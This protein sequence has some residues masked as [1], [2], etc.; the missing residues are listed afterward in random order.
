MRLQASILLLLVAT[1]FSGQAATKAAAPRAPL[2]KILERDLRPVAPGTVGE[3][4]HPPFATGDCSLCHERA[5]AANPGK[6]IKAGNDL[7]FG[8]HEDYPGILSRKFTHL[9]A[10][11]RCVSCHNPHNS[12]EP[13]LLHAPLK[14][15]CFACHEEIQSLAEKSLVKHG[16]IAAEAKCMACHNPHGADVEH[17]LL[18]M[19]RDLCLNC[20]SRDGVKDAEGHRITNMKRLLD[21]NPQHHGALRFGDCSACHNPHGFEHFRLLN[22]QYP[23]EFYSHYDPALYAL[24]FE[25][26]E[27]SAFTE[28]QT[29]TLTQ[30]R[31]GSRNLHHLH[32]NKDELGRTCRACHEVHASKLPHLIRGSVPYGDSGWMLKINYTS[33]LTGG[34]CSKT[35]H[36]EEAYDNSIVSPP[37]VPMAAQQPLARISRASVGTQIPNVELM[38]LDGVKR[39][40]F[41]GSNVTVLVFF[42]PDQEH[43]RVALQQITPVMREFASKPV[44]WIGLVSDRFAK[45]NVLEEV[46][47]RGVELPVLIDAG[48]AMYG[49]FGVAQEPA[50]GFIDRNHK[51]AAFQAF[52]KVNQ[53]E[54]LRARVHHLLGE[55][56]DH[57]LELVLRPPPM[58]T[59][60]PVAGAHTRL[61]LAERLFVAGRTQL[62]LEGVKVSLTEDPKSV[63]AHVLHGR[64]LVGLGQQVEARAAFQTALQIEPG[65]IEARQA[66]E[67]AAQPGSKP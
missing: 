15:L 51:Y 3:T 35:C 49:R 40:L 18:Q 37:V 50:F 45:S 2:P 39:G 62:A 48:D 61:R 38:T 57:Q 36:G 25:C 28:A 47:R 52:A 6:V 58:A 27:A 41:Q 20:H 33:T 11:E 56:S 4:S 8:C 5:D 9:A 10:S 19:P 60:G 67:A 63:T 7:C 13:K 12:R 34:S 64:I 21:Q 14:D 59:N 44:R 53:A 23:A 30:F 29:T 42:K 1:A 55:I 66:L 54:I 65:N 16:A 46:S 32:V 26:H 17:M 43:S 31:D 22:E 24:C